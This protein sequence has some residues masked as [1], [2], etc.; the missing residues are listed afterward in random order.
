MLLVVLVVAATAYG[1][2]QLSAGRA[3]APARGGNH[4]AASRGRRQQDV[5]NQD[6][7]GTEVRR[8]P[9]GSGAQGGRRRE[10]R[11]GGG[12]SAADGPRVFVDNGCG[13]CHSLAELGT[14]AQGTIGP[15]LDEALV[16]KDAKFIQTS[17]VDPSADVAEGFPDGTM[18]QDYKSS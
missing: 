18:P 10:R 1:A 5:T 14:D 3:G 11:A 4:E 15:N 12:G 17:I 16:D 6:T 7:G 2:V 8:P 9:P 13:S